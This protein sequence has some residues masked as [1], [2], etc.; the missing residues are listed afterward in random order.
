MKSFYI[1][2]MFHCWILLTIIILFWY[3]TAQQGGGIS[4]DNVFEGF[5]FTDRSFVR[6]VSKPTTFEV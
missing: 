1:I 2:E 5:T 4:T 3:T 6:P